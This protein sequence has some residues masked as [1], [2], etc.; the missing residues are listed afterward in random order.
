[1]IGD[2]R[3]VR[4]ESGTCYWINQSS[5]GKCK[6]PHLV[7]CAGSKHSFQCAPELIPTACRGRQLFKKFDVSRMYRAG[8]PNEGPTNIRGKNSTC[9]PRLTHP[10][11]VHDRSSADTFRWSNQSSQMYRQSIARRNYPTVLAPRA[12]CSH[13]ADPCIEQ[14]IPRSAL[15]S[16][17]AKPLRRET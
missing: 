8:Q 6:W 3:N 16:A 12:R 9:L 4:R 15:P 10:S 2:A 14:P 1:M 17:L 11:V 13:L 7:R 5:D